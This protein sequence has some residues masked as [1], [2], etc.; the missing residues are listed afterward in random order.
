MALI[1]LALAPVAL[2]LFIQIRFLPYHSEGITWGHRG[3]LA[4]DL[5]L[6]W[7]LWPG[8][9][10]GWG[11]RLWPRRVWTIALLLIF[12][13]VALFYAGAVAN[14]PDEW[15][16]VATKGVRETLDI[17]KSA[18]KET[19]ETS[20][21]AK[22]KHWYARLWPPNTLDL[23][24]QDLVDDA[25]LEQIKKREAAGSETKWIANL[26]LRDR[27][28]VEA[29]LTNADV[30]HAEFSG[31]NLARARLDLVWAVKAHF[32]CSDCA[33]SL[34][35]A[36]LQGASLD[37]AQLQGASLV[38]AQ[39][40]GASLVV[41]QLQGASL[42]G[43]QLQGASLFGAQLQGASLVV[44]QLQGASL[45]GAQLQGASLD[46][47]QLQGASLDGAQLQGAS[48]D[49]AQLQ[50]ASLDLAQLQGALVEKASVWRGDAR[51]ANAE[52][53][54]IVFDVEKSYGCI[55]MGLLSLT[56]FV[57]RL[58][59]GICE[60]TTQSFDQLQQF[61]ID[62]IPAGKQRDDALEKIAKRLKPDTLDDEAAIASDWREKGKNSAPPSAILGAWQE[63]GCAREGEPYVVRALLGRLDK[64]L[65]KD[66]AALKAKLAQAFLASTCDG[67]KGLKDEEI[68]KLKA[69]AKPAAKA[70]SAAGGSTCAA[71]E[72]C[73]K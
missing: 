65:F 3:L 30:Q 42:L 33:K 5:L 11:V 8:F 54:H 53:A 50:G 14:F 62:R 37:G 51:T 45:N 57:S 66:R 12:S 19:S 27:D 47:A 44:A 73:P 9:R 70:Q 71:T 64:P 68:A 67:A 72:G 35:G 2:L 60:P 34:L 28:F 46:G 52:K 61:L 38:V 41:A 6:V 43:A 20:E 69:I 18:E 49:G 26:R 40:Q 15:I 32:E 1:T 4:L 7:T 17:A 58:A 23:R 24:N 63:I 56:E 48:L 16:Y 25:K 36:Q 31:A 22:P 13:A 55:S 10:S 59:G 21:N 29:D 39:L